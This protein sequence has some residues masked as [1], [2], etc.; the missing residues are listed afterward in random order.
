MSYKLVG[1]RFPRYTHTHI[2]IYIY[3]FVHNIIYIT[4]Y[5]VII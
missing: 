4:L 2:Y 1:S 5:N 3:I